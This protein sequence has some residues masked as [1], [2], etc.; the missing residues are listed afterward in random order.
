M[1]LLENATDWLRVAIALAAYAGLR[2]GEVR[3]LEVRDVDLKRN[4][5]HIR[6]AFS[7]SEVLTPKSGDERLVPI[8]PPLRDILVEAARDKLPHAR[9]VVLA[10]GATPSR[11]KVLRSLQDLE[12]RIAKSKEMQVWSFHQ[13]RHSFCSTLVRNGV[14]VEAVRVL[15]G[16][17]DRKTTRSATSTPARPTSKPPCSRSHANKRT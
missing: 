13:L 3:A 15:A 14:S 1:T 16:H 10:G 7:A 6:R 17:P 9:I 5:L 2:S 8:A 4:E 11:Q 12:R